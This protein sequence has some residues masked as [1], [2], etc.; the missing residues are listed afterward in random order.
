MVFRR[1]VKGSL[2]VG[3]RR[4]TFS[5]PKA[6]G[7]PF[8]GCLTP[9]RLPR[10]V[11]PALHGARGRKRTITEVPGGELE[12]LP[13]LPFFVLWAREVPKRRVS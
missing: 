3:P 2:R 7:A 13:E 12:P 1:K 6:F 4:L 10:P 5:G 11:G 9:K 8:K